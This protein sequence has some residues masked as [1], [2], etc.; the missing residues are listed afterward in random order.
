MRTYSFSLNRKQTDSWRSDS[1]G[2][3]RCCLRTFARRV[4][5]A[6]QCERVDLVDA[7]GI[8]LETIPVNGKPRDEAAGSAPKSE[9]R[10]PA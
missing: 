10:M 8:R 6:K 4:G 1:S 7:A 3:W 5:E 9:S 2:A